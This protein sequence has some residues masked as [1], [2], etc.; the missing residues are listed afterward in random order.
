M[1]LKSLGTY[2]Y[3]SLEDFLAKKRLVFVKAS[4][5][6]EGEVNNL[7]IEGSKIAVLIVLDETKYPKD[8]I[9]NFGEQLIIKIRGVAPSAF[10]KLR[11]L[12]TVVEITDIE[13][14]TVYGDFKNQ[15]SVIAAIKVVEANEAKK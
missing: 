1:A 9:S 13:R 5:W 11:P 2:T 10:A 8:D 4:Q 14:C 7:K 12:D 3:F 15:L 6:G